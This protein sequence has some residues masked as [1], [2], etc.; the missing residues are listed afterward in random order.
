MLRL[1]KV[2][3]VNPTL[4][5]SINVCLVCRNCQKLQTHKKWLTGNDNSNED[6]RVVSAENQLQRE[7]KAPWINDEARMLS[8]LAR[9]SN[10][11]CVVALVRGMFVLI[12]VLYNFVFV[13]TFIVVYIAYLYFSEQIIIEI[14]SKLESLVCCW[15]IY[16]AKPPIYG[17]MLT[18]QMQNWNSV[19]QVNHKPA[20]NF[21]FSKKAATVRVND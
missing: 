14:G 15:G 12:M 20:V 10:E 5:K 4:L 21:Y 1:T 11:K 7:M 13:F 17:R 9:F 3:T 6:G 18:V 19:N 2:P 16:W 8:G